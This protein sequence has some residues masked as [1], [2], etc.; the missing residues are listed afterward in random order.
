MFG[1]WEIFKD[2][3][4]THNCLFTQDKRINRIQILFSGYNLILVKAFGCGNKLLLESDQS[5][6]SILVIVLEREQKLLICL[7]VTE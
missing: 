4:R 6:I 2:E 7:L 5:L 1:Q 3:I